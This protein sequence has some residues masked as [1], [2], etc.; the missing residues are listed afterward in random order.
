[1]ENSIYSSPESDLDIE[2]ESESILASR[3]SRLGAALLDG[4]L[5]L[6]ITLPLMHFTGGFDV[7]SS[8]VQPTLLYTLGV[9]FVGVIFFVL[10]H[11]YF[12]INYGQT[13]GKKIMGIKIVTTDNQLPGLSNYGKRYGIFWI[14]PLIPGIGQWINMVNILFIFSKSKRCLHDRAGDT[15]VVLVENKTEGAG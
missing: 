13:I 10:I 4:L 1:M 2:S 15:M 3:W 9:S 11:G 7:I 14:I 5:V 8:G 12:L 6:P